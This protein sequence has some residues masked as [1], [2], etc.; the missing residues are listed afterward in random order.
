MLYRHNMSKEQSMYH[1]T[2]PK[3]TNEEFDSHKNI[4]YIITIKSVVATK[5]RTQITGAQLQLGLQM[6]R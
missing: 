1:K 4:K 3:R 5:V 2:N 6:M